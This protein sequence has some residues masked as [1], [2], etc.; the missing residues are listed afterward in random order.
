MFQRKTRTQAAITTTLVALVLVLPATAGTLDPNAGE[1]A[2]DRLA[3]ALDDV[4]NGRL[5]HADGDE[6]DRLAFSQAQFPYVSNGNRGEDVRAI[7]YLLKARGYSIGVDGVFGSGT[8]SVVKSFQ[9]SQG[10]GSDGIVG[11]NTWNALVITVSQGATGDAVRA[12]QSQLNAKRNAGLAVDGI[13]GSGTKS[14]VQS[15]QTHAGISSDG[16]V[17]PTTWKNLI[18]H[19]DQVGNTSNVC[20]YYSSSARWGTGSAVGQLEAAAAEFKATGNGK[21]SVGDLSLEH[22]GDISG[23]A[24]HE[25]GLDVDL[26]PVR[27]DSGQCSSGCQWNWSC[28]DRSGTRKLIQSIYNKAPGHVKVIWFNDPTL[29]NEGLVQP[30]SNHDNHLHVRYCEKYHADSRYDC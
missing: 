5:P 11:P 27:T 22:G 14:V 4:A 3:T 6:E 12:V 9:T 10:L 23:H 13:F 18:W 20:G 29:I 25:D 16:I 1:V 7:Q 8:E 21:M 28:Y 17:G 30:L 26:R 24:S 15:F 19:Y 2:A